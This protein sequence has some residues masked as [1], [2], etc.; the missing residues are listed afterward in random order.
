[1]EKLRLFQILGI[2][3]PTD[4]MS[5]DLVDQFTVQEPTWDLDSLLARAEAKHPAL[6]ALRESE[7]AAKW[8]ARAA[9]TSYLPSLSISAG[10]SGYTQQF[11][12]PDPLIQSSI[13]SQQKSADQ[14]IAA[15]QQQNEILSR[16]TNPLP[17]SDCSQYV[18]TSADAASL[19]QQIRAQ[20]S[21]FPF[22]FTPQPFQ[23]SVYVSLP[24]FNGFQREL[25]L[26]QA[27]ARADNARLAA[28]DRILQ[29]HAD[30]TSRFYDLQRAYRTIAIQEDARAAGRDQL[31][32]ATQRYRL[33]QGSFYELLQAQVQAQTAERDYVNAVYEFH[34][35]EVMLEE[36]AGMGE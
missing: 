30:V 34:R 17:P 12:N 31:Q 15:C 16:L 4:V 14:E 8:Q 32:L 10:W 18:F 3:P 36:A 19:E 24:I 29:I 26:S 7:A 35:A 2:E 25:Q 13:T 11:T 33:G 9:R 6:V 28:N 1:M 22:S 5:I 21:V 27:E 20:N 23:A